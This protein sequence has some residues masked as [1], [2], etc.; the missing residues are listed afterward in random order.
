VTNKLLRIADVMSATG[1]KKPAIYSSIAAG[2]FPKP[3]KLGLRMV[4][5]VEA[6]VDKW[7]E[8]KIKAGR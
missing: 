6:D 1:L 2:E 8:A 4:A 5:W 3:I 7:I